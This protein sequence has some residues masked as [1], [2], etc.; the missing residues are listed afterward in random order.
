[1]I[2]SSEIGSPI[3]LDP[4]GETEIAPLRS[5][6]MQQSLL[7]SHSMY[8]VA[9]RQLKSASSRKPSLLTHWLV[10][11]LMAVLFPLTMP[12]QQSTTASSSSPAQPVQLSADPVQPLTA[13]AE[14]AQPATVPARR[15]TLPAPPPRAV[16]D[17]EDDQ[18]PASGEIDIN[19]GYSFD[20]FKNWGGPSVS[21]SFEPRN[22]FNEW[23]AGV[24]RVEEFGA[25]GYLFESGVD[26]DL[27]DTWDVGLN[28]GGANSFFLPQIA[29][30]IT[31][32]RRWF[33]SDKFVTMFDG[34][35]LR[36]QDVH[37]DYRWGVGAAYQF[38]RPWAVE[39]GVNID[40]S[41]PGN[42]ATEYQYVAVTQGR[43]KK[44]LVTLR[45]EFGR[46]AY[47]AIGPDTDISNFHS[48]GVSLKL[49]KWVGADW[50]FVATGN[51]YSNPFYQDKGIAVGF[52]KEFSGGRRHSTRQNLGR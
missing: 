32:S 43:E 34:S 16:S 6:V 20:G 33:D 47:Q 7:L 3:G 28:I 12:G 9:L 51:Y 29:A 13:I 23:S 24:A 39:A 22:S 11:M 8:V 41:T 26:R 25:T 4:G 21:G 2:A 52:F 35:Y 27:T 36:W 15:A 38:D 30:D 42:V 50:G 10:T 46:E 19:G 1:M 37:R 48:Y 45:G 40:V 44:Y 5:I 18:T 14:P 49:R 17:S 31:A